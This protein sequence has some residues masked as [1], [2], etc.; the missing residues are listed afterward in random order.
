MITLPPLG[1]LETGL[2]HAL[3]DIAEQMP[4]DWTLIGGQ[5]VLLHA[6]EHGRTTPRVS[7]DLDLVVDARVRPPAIP[8]MVATLTAL[9]FEESPIGV[10]E[11]AHRFIK[12]NAIVDVLAPDGLGERT[13]LRTVGSA[14][15]VAVSGGTYALSRSEPV[16]VQVDGRRGVAHRPDLCGALVVKS[17]AAK[18]DTR[19][20][21]ERHLYDLALLYSLVADPITAS[22]ELGSKNRARLR[23]VTELADPGAEYWTSIGDR[24]HAR[25]AHAAYTLLTS[26]QR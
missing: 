17:A 13:S 5:M 16:D 8:A 12:G 25:D 19:R 1:D 7:R 18:H 9:N 3:L 6:L 24:E 4:G 15:T 23:S 11:V 10:D 20:G 14:A 2:W 22:Q 26:A 21:P